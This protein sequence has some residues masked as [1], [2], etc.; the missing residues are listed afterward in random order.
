MKRIFM[1]G[2]LFSFLFLSPTYLT[3][4]LNYRD[5]DLIK[6]AFMNGCLRTIAAIEDENTLKRIKVK[7]GAAVEFVF[8]MTD[9]YIA[10]IHR[11]NK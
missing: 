10:E 3:A 5:L 4:T 1:G 11:L 9:K 2:V 8:D 7:P 6:V